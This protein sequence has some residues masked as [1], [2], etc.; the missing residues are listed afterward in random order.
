MAAVGENSRGKHLVLEVPEANIVIFMSVH[1]AKVASRRMSLMAEVF[2][3]NGPDTLIRLKAVPGS[4]CDAI[5]GLL[6]DRLK[7][8]VIAPPEGGKANKAICR[9]LSKT[10]GCPVSIDAGCGSPLKTARAEGLG[11]DQVE[12]ALEV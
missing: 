12:A 6:G 5:A 8:R 3:A 9:L 7:I 2:T 1:A 4:S 10:L 11:P